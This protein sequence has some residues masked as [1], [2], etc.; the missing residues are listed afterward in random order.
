M[1]FTYTTKLLKEGETFI[2]HSPEFD[3]SSCG[4][5]PDEA[6]RHLHEATVL[7]VE[8]ARKMGT[9]DRILPTFTIPPLNGKRGKGELSDVCIHL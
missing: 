7:F 1:Q 5:S 8:E 4:D 2:A 9:L 6:R 3:L